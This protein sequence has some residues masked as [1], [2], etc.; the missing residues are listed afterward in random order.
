[1]VLDTV[2]IQPLDEALSSSFGRPGLAPE[3]AQRLFLLY[4]I[5]KLFLI[6]EQG[7]PPYLALGLTSYIPGPEEAPVF[8]C[9]GVFSCVDSMQ[10]A[11]TVVSGSSTP[12]D[13]AGKNTGEGGQGVGVGGLWRFPSRGSS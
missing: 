6:F 10:T 1:M 4:S 9:V 12:W 7:T 13:S 11:W 5:L 3:G 2:L 8:F